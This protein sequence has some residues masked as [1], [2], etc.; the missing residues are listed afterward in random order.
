MSQSHPRSQP[1]LTSV[2]AHLYVRD[3]QAS[4]AFFTARLGFTIDFVCGDPPFY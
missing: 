4:I 3:I 1:I 2:A